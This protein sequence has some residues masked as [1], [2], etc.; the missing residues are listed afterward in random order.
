MDS[1]LVT[2]EYDVEKRFLDTE[3]HWAK[4]EID[5][6]V[7]KGIITGMTATEFRPQEKIT[8]AQFARLLVTALGIKES[9]GAALSFEDVPA[10]A[11]YRDAV[12]A[13][14]HA[15]LITGYSELVFAPDENITRE[16]M[17]SIISRALQMKSGETVADDDTEQIINKF[18]DKGDLSPWARQ[19]IALAISKGIVS[20]MSA[21]TFAPGAFATRAEAAVMI[22]RLYEQ[23]H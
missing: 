21:D 1:E 13:A 8:R 14:V 4:N 22:L 10:G 9:K 6:L 18:K 2:F 12:A 23:V 15:G 7:E 17:A 20:G 5:S 16:Q 19:G 11:W 3:N